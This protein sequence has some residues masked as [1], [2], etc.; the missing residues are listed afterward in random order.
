MKL[1]DHKLNVMILDE[2][3]VVLGDENYF[4]AVLDALLSKYYDLDT[5]E[6]GEYEFSLERRGRKIWR[7][8]KKI[9]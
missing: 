7:V 2:H 9:W 4:N 3:V 6:T 8:M 5:M 1:K